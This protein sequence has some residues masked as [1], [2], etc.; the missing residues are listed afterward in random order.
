MLFALAGHLKVSVPILI[1][2]FVS[3]GHGM[4]HAHHGPIEIAVAGMLG[5]LVGFIA[6]LL[7]S[8]VVRFIAFTA[9]RDGGK[10]RWVVYGA[11]AGGLGG[12]LWEAFS[13]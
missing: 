8:K 5:A 1:G 9:G 2:E 7:V 11:L 3:S 13:D 10:G 4:P 12:A 6:G